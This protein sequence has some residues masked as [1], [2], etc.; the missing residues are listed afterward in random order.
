MGMFQ[1]IL[2]NIFD[3]PTLIENESGSLTFKTK[4][5]R[6]S[7]IMTS[8][9]G[10]FFKFDELV[11][12]YW[13]NIIT[14]KSLVDID[15]RRTYT[16]FNQ[17]IMFILH[18]NNKTHIFLKRPIKVR[19]YNLRCNIINEEAVISPAIFKVVS[20]P[21]FTILWGQRAVVWRPLS[22]TISHVYLIKLKHVNFTTVNWFEIVI[23]V[24]ISNR[25]DSYS[26]GSCPKPGLSLSFAS[27]IKID[28]MENISR[29]N[30][31]SLY[32]RLRAEKKYVSNFQYKYQAFQKNL[33]ERHT[34]GMCCVYLTNIQHI[35]E[36][37]CSKEPILTSRR[38]LLTFTFFKCS[39]IHSNIKINNA[40]LVLLNTNFLCRTTFVRQRQL[41]RNNW[42]PLQIKLAVLLNRN[43]D[44]TLTTTMIEYFYDTTNLKSRNEINCTCH[45]YY[46]HKLGGFSK[47]LMSENEKN[48]SWDT[49]NRIPKITTSLVKWVSLK[50]LSAKWLIK[51]KSPITKTENNIFESDI[52][53]NSNDI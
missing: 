6:C 25:I 13:L 12:M 23:D 10:Q 50:R 8:T 45:R 27:I 26:S 2:Q 9:V 51:I 17:Y 42:N 37:T 15:Y 24:V 43:D 21:I 52:K 53:L 5:E 29:P 22:Y 49:G 11:T 36:K 44:D 18:F 41:V 14:T 16:R 48:N 35:I 7:S 3:Y 34:R 32:H 39:L 33:R 30:S 28:E 47:V 38:L 31:T 1:A 40:K 19:L 46:R 4:R 20:T